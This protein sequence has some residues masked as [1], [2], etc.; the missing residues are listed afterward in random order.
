MKGS[1]SSGGG[2]FASGTCALS[3]LPKV[4]FG[5]LKSLTSMMMKK[6]PRPIGGKYILV[7]N[8]VNVSLL[9]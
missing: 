5:S 2:S 1:S 9:K 4:E 8:S 6:I 3:I 7:E